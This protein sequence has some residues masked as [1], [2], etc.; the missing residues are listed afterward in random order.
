MIVSK[1]LSW[2]TKTCWL[3]SWNVADPESNCLRLS[4]L[5]LVD[6][7]V[8]NIQAKAFGHILSRPLSSVS[9]PLFYLLRIQAFWIYSNPWCPSHWV[10]VI[11]RIPTV[12]GM[13][14]NLYFRHVWLGQRL[15]ASLWPFLLLF[16]P[17]YLSH[18]LICHF[19]VLCDYERFMQPLPSWDRPC[20]TW[21]DV[22][23][24]PGPARSH[25]AQE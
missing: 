4:L 3:E 13:T 9:L 6:S 22:S 5:P 14:V 20:G 25:L 7:I 10:K 24:F 17:M 12:L 23:V 8:H 15:P 1:R 16:L 21:T 19:P 18:T 11:W 2:L